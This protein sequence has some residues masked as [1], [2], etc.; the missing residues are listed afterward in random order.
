MKKILLIDNYDSF[1]FNLQ[2]YLE[3]YDTQITVWRN[4]QFD[5]EEVEAFDAIVIS[6][7]PGLPKQ[8][9]IIMDVIHQ[10]HQTKPI[11]GICL[12]MQAIG[13]YFGSELKNLSQVFHG[14]SSTISIVEMDEKLFQNLPT[15]IQVGRYHSWVVNNP[16]PENLIITSMDEDKNIMSIKHEF[17]N[18][19]G[20]QFHPESILTPHGKEMISNWIQSIT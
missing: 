12:G 18:V 2:H 16:L 14:V 8:A 7:G 20:V 15:N 4:D 3:A 17:Y 5:I 6:P 11:L 13:E 9:G 1:T 10:Y 19:R